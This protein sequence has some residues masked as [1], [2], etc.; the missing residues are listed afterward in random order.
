M[1]IALIANLKL[2]NSLNS[3]LKVQHNVPETMKASWYSSVVEH[4]QRV[5]DNLTDTPSLKNYLT[6][7]LEKSYPDARKL[8]IKEVKLAK[9]GITIPSENEY[10]LNCP[11][12]VE[13]ILD[14]DFY[15]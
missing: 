12:S 9:F 1:S 11:F 7:A 10:P 5:I 6:E 4:R 14:E 2:S 15:P 3:I 8:A 13:Q